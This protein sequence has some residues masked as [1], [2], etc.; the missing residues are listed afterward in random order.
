[1]NIGSK[2]FFLLPNLRQKFNDHKI[3]DKISVHLKGELATV[4]KVKKLLNKVVY[5]IISF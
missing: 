2:N 1:M 4:L 3:I 5:K